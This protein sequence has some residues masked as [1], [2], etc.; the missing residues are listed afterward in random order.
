MYQ[1]KPQTKQEKRGPSRYLR[2]A[3]CA[4]SPHHAVCVM[5]IQGGVQHPR[6][7]AFHLWVCACVLLDLFTGINNRHI[8]EAKLE[9]VR[10]ESVA[11]A[12]RTT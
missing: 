12:F 3:D 11:K 10:T 2:C 4:A 9:M 5:G 1:L 8:G 7:Q 6:S